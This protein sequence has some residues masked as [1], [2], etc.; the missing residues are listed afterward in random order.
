MSKN[1]RKRS[2]NARRSRLIIEVRG[3]CRRRHIKTGAQ[4]CVQYR[5]QEVIVVSFVREITL[6]FSVSSDM[7]NAL[8]V[9]RP[10]T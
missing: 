8:G 6:R 4:M 9:V 3:T 10:D 2:S 1:K 5:S 7:E